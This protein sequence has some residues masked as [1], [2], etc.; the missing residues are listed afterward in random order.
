MVSHPQG[1]DQ[2]HEEP[3]SLCIICCTSR[4][5]GPGDAAQCCHS[6]PRQ[7]L[8]AGGGGSGPDPVL[9]AVLPAGCVFSQLIPALFVQCTQGT[10]LRDSVRPSGVGGGCVGS[11]V[12][13]VLAPRH[14]SAGRAKPCMQWGWV[15]AKP[16]AAAHP[17]AATVVLHGG[18]RGRS[19]SWGGPTHHSGW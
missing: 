17:H 12:G 13:G 14:G 10:V 15:G 19:P 5:V 9:I 1:P 6:P 11:S 4:D 18:S 8:A 16:L 2:P 7:P 3:L